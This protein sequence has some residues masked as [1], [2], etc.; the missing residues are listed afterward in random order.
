MATSD[1]EIKECFKCFDTDN[2][3]KL[4]VSDIGQVIRALGKAPL[5]SEVEAMEEEAG[6]ETVDYDTFVKFYQRRMKKPRDLEE[7]MR[8][9]FKAMDASGNGTITTA[10]L[11]MLLCSLGEPLFGDEVDS[12]ARCVNVDTEGNLSYDELVDLLVK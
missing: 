2:D 5:Q 3:N 12:L 4:L 1:A 7:D 11:N 8:R 6:G 10:E 9:A